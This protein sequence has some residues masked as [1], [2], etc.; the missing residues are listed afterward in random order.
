[1]GMSPWRFIS[2]KWALAVTNPDGT[3][4]GSAGGG[5]GAATIADGADV[6]QGAI[7]DA[8]VAAGASG[9]LSAKLRRL[10]TDL[11]DLINR[12]PAA[13]TVGGALKTANVDVNGAELNY[14][15][16]GTPTSINASTSTTVATLS[17]SDNTLFGR[18]VFN[19]STAFLYVKCGSSATSSSFWCRLDPGGYCETPFGYWGILTGILASG[20]GTARVTEFR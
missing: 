15:G 9:S 14:Q 18:A 20:T 12:F 10:T 13:I 11:S 8:V 16:P 4:I 2:G 6:T 5:G 7:A 1:M 3:A 19:D 17:A